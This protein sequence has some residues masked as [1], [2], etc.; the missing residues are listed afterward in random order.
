MPASGMKGR[1][2]TLEGGEGS[3]KT[4]Q[5]A[6]LARALNGAGYDCLLTREPGG[7]PAGEDIRHLLVAPRSSPL[8]PVSQTLLHSAARKEH[9]KTV[10][11]PALSAGR[12]V[13]C[14]RFY[15]STRAYQG[16]ALGVESSLIEDL[17][18]LT[19][20]GQH[21]DLSL[22]LDIPPE[23]GLRRAQKRSKADHYERLAMKYHQAVRDAFL[24]IAQADSQRCAVID[25]CAS[26]KDVQN[27]IWAIAERRFSLLPLP[28]TDQ[29]DHAKH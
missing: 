18:A 20:D 2:I 3:G 6:L 12:W 24:A 10:I 26:E 4:T 5:A 25:A 8:D 19:T 9:W 27:A 11:K 1:F 14:D 7:T 23:T 22:F 15:D 17:I 28:K 29:P 13:V 21:P 16:G